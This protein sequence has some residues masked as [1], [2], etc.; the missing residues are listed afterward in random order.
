M[1]AP[2]CRSMLGVASTIMDNSSGTVG[3]R[4]DGFRSVTRQFALTVSVPAGYPTQSLVNAQLDNRA[5]SMD[6]K[7]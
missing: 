5:R 6:T 1:P 4:T 7:L 3:V 2:A